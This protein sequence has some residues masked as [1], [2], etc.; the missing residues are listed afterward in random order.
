MLAVRFA[1]V[2]KAAAET[3]SPAP[4]A[5]LKAG[6]DAGLVS[7]TT[8]CLSYLL[9]ELTDPFCYSPRMPAHA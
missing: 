9:V 5:A 2:P 6:P 4:V 8:T 7:L 3:K 1:E